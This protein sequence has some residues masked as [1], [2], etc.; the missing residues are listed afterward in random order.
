[1]QTSGQKVSELLPHGA[2]MVLLDNLLSWEE[3]FI[4]TGLT[5]RAGMPFYEAPHGV[6]CHVGLEYMAQ[7]CGVYAGLLGIRAGRSVRLG[8]LLGTR[9]FHAETGH[10]AE[11]V[12]LTITAREILRED[13]M[14]VFDCRIMDGDKELASAQLNLYQPDDVEAIL[15]GVRK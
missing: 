2:E 14:G 9:N 10:F 13:K 12:N 11:G 5:I 1:M 6:P 15:N 8:F 7:A 4:S 3:G